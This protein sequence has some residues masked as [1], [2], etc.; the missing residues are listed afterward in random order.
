MFL[1]IALAMFLAF[2]A[3]IICKFFDVAPDFFCVQFFKILAR[4]MLSGRKEVSK[5]A[6]A[7]RFVALLTFGMAC[8]VS[9]M[10]IS[11]RMR[12]IELVI[13]VVGMDITFFAVVIMSVWIVSKEDAHIQGERTLEIVP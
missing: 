7:D 5:A 9:L 12:T 1:L 3:Q 8:I 10:A 6:R 4:E 13:V 2:A 11:A